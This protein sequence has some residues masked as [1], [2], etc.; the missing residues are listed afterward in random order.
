MVTIQTLLHGKPLCPPTE[1]SAFKTPWGQST[2]RRDS[3]RSLSWLL[4]DGMLAH[5]VRKRRVC[6]AL[7][8]PRAKLGRRAHPHALALSAPS[9]PL[10]KRCSSSFFTWKLFLSLSFF[11]FSS[12]NSFAHLFMGAWPLSMSASPQ[13][14][15]GAVHFGERF[16]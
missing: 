16:C 13:C 7:P 12:E 6:R 2:I 4:A 10:R 15:D 8:S 1:T 11:L 5:R 9:R 14:M 3:S